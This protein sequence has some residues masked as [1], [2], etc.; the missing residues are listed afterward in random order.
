VDLADE[1]GDVRVGSLD[2]TIPALG[3]GA[4]QL[5]NAYFV[6]ANL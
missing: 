5:I 6:N 2:E 3:L 1:H 4:V